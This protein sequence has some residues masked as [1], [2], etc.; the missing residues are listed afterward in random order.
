[1]LATCAGA[2]WAALA[3]VSIERTLDVGTVRVSADAHHEGA[4]DLYVPLVDWGVR[5]PGAV[6]VPARVALDLRTVDRREAERLARGASPTWT[7]CATRP[8]ERSRTG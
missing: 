6:D 8:R 5:F 7:R 3:I 4:L 2:A 1:M